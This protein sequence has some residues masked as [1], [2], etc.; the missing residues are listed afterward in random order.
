[1]VQIPP[2]PSITPRQM[3]LLRVLSTAMAWSDGCLAAEEVDVMIDRFSHMFA[4]D[5][6]QQQVLQHE[7][8]DYMMQNIH[9]E[10]LTPQLQSLEEKELVLR[11]G[12]EVIGASARTPEEDKI[13]IHEATAYQK[14]VS[15][16]NLAPETI[17]RIETEADA[18]P[19][20]DLIDS[21]TEQLK[22]FMSQG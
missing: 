17:Q 10:E 19:Q 5:A 8:Q 2:P 21:L 3:N 12:Y 11:L 1:M 14:L 9:L 18:R 15:L 13:N 4:T 20:T 16:L 6:A 7:L 22:Q